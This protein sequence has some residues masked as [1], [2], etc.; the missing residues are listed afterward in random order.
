[1]GP[2]YKLNTPMACPRT[3]KT[4]RA[5]LL[6]AFVHC[7]SSHVA[8]PRCAAGHLWPTQSLGYY[9]QHGSTSNTAAP[10]ARQHQ[11]HGSPISTSNYGGSNYQNSSMTSKRPL[12][13]M[14]SSDL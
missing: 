5:I 1:M 14:S 3:T 12:T 2:G 9:Q 4:R 11:Q 6:E 10:A 7:A 8:M 13:S